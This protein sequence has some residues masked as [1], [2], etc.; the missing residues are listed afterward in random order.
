M[1]ISFLLIWVRIL[2][3]YSYG[4]GYYGHISIVEGLAIA[5]IIIFIQLLGSRIWMSLFSDG[6][7][8]KLIRYATY[9]R[10]R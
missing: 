10:G 1:H 4:L 3:I 8:E 2:R 6:P 5:G 7:L 9:G